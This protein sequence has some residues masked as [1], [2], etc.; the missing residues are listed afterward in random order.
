V[1]NKT[2]LLLSILM[3]A[4]LAGAQTATTSV[5]DRV[6]L[7][8]GRWCAPEEKWCSP[9]EAPEL[10]GTIRFEVTH[11][12]KLKEVRELHN[13]VVAAGKAGI[14]SRINGSGGEAAFT[15]I[16]IGTGTTSPANGNT[17]CET[18]ITTNGGARAN[19]TASR[20]TTDDTN[21]TAQVVVTYN[22][23][24]SFAVTE[25]C[26]LNASSA[27][28]LLSRQTFSAVNVVSGDAL[29]VTWKIDVD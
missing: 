13:L 27:G 22:F 25:S 5:S 17:T 14:A 3:A 7:S 20:V 1:R 15:Y 19:G 18:E 28:T 4:P 9:S 11:E 26:L 29:T 8:R 23:T 21:D 2:A 6:E 16:A 12:G 24:G 10:V